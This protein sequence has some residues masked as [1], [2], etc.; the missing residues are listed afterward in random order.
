MSS[1]EEMEPLLAAWAL[2]GL[3]LMTVLMVVTI[4]RVVYVHLTEPLFTCRNCRQLIGR[5]QPIDPSD[6]RKKAEL[7]RDHEKVCI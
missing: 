4:V 5:P 2:V 1:I 7:R 3:G 6:N